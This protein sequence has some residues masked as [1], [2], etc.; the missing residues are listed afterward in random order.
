MWM[1]IMLTRLRAGRDH[2]VQL[3]ARGR[4]EFRFDWLCGFGH[5]EL[6]GALLSAPL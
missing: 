4:F 5:L 2:G 6:F 3:R 1:G